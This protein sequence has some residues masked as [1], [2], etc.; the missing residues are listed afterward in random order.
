MLLVV[1]LII[2]TIQASGQTQV[3]PELISVPL[4]DISTIN[5]EHSGQIIAGND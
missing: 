2:L 5:T 3:P 1:T 4:D